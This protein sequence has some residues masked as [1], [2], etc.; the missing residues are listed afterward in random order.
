MEQENLDG[1]G[2]SIPVRWTN[3]N[4]EERMW[5]AQD[6]LNR[7]TE[8]L[9]VGHLFVVDI[10]QLHRLVLNEQE[11]IKVETGRALLKL[12]VMMRGALMFGVELQMEG[13]EDRLKRHKRQIPS[14]VKV[15]D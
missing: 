4:H 10:K 8:E 1:L 2:N 6:L 9:K 3:L 14:S 11:P 15:V 13:R 12:E 7:F 5:W